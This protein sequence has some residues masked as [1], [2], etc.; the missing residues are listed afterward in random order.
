MRRGQSLVSVYFYFVSLADQGNG[1]AHAKTLA[2]ML[3]TGTVDEW[4]FNMAL[5]SILPTVDHQ[6]DWPECR[7]F[8]LSTWRRGL[9]D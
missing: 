6:R 4:D 7:S 2:G 9:T 8:L 3:N 1:Q 5:M